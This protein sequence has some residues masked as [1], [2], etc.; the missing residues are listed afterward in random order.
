MME[1]TKPEET[2]PINLGNPKE[3]TMLAL[4]EAVIRMTGSSSRIEFQPLPV[5]DPKQRRPDIARAER[6]AWLGAAMA[7]GRR[8]PNDHQLFQKLD[9]LMQIARRPKLLLSDRR[10]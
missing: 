8:S 2:G 7:I 6:G 3:L 9:G 1:N 4:A 10:P 5:D